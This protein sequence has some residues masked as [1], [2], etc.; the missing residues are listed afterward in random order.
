MAAFLLVIVMALIFFIGR[1]GKF[2]VN[3]GFNG[4]CILLNN[5]YLF[6]DFLVAPICG[7]L[8]IE[9]LPGIDYDCGDP[10]NHTGICPWCLVN[11][12]KPN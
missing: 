4:G 12:C 11:G 8:A 3:M 1:R 5:P 6:V 7:L 10:P 2:N 9:M